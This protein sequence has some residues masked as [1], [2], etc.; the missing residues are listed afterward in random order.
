MHHLSE[1]TYEFFTSGSADAVKIPENLV[2]WSKRL[3]I[4]CFCCLVLG[5]VAFVAMQKQLPGLQI[6]HDVRIIR[7][8]Q[9]DI[10]IIEGQLD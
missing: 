10:Q 9:Q 3:G 5:A 4:A 8:R 6:C 7:R 2:K 1:V